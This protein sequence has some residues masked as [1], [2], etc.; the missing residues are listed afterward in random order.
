MEHIDKWYQH[1]PAPVVENKRHKPLWDLSIQTDRV[2]EHRRPDIVI[3][4]WEE[5]E[6][7]IIDVAIPAD[8]NIA[9]KEWE[10]I[11]KYSELK[12]EV[13]RLWNIRAKK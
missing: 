6:C 7:L 12:L 2:I 8:Q 13:M 4:D 5:K 3:V 1:Q 11:S 10:K 9:D